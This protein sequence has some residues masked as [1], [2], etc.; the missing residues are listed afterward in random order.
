MISRLRSLLCAAALLTAGHLSAQTPGC[1]HGE[2]DDSGMAVSVAVLAHPTRVAA[3][4]DSLLQVQGYAI[5]GSP[6]GL[7]RWN[8]QPRFTWLREVEEED[9][10]GD[11]HPG[12]QLSVETEARGDSTAV[13]VGARVLCKVPP[14]KGGPDDI[15]TM[16]ELLSASMLATGL[17]E[18]LDSLRAAG[19]DPLT[20]VARERETVH[21]P[22]AV[23]KFRMVGRQD[24]PDPRL[25]SNVRYARDDGRYV[26]IYVYPGMRVDSAC[27]AACAV[28]TEADGFVAGF[29]ELVRA[30]HF[31]EATV[32]RDERPQ[33]GAGA[34]W[35]YGRHLT[36]KMRR[37][38]QVVD[39]HYYLYAFPGFLLKVRAT[40]P[41]SS[42]TLRDVTAF[43]DELLRT[44][45]TRSE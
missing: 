27:D 38:G 17:P 25:G 29:P 24:Y 9:W 10:H 6:E 5:G 30:G 1:R 41:P 34:P 26:D 18:A 16:V 13:E 3:T 39:S 36:L 12:V 37:E 23:G 33:P 2:A 28:N 35:A 19:V 43:V 15:G 7:G 8:V 4:L 11:E 21:A 45:M 32:V 22:E 44:L 20:P 40:F 14:A 31:E 42:D